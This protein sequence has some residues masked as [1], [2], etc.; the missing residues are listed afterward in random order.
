MCRYTQ[1]VSGAHVAHRLSSINEI[2]EEAVVPHEQ[3]DDESKK[4]TQRSA[5]MLAEQSSQS[6]QDCDSH[7]R[8][9]THRY[10]SQNHALSS[11]RL[12]ATEPQLKKEGLEQDVK[13]VW[14]STIVI[15]KRREGEMMKIREKAVWW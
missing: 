10:P 3:Q 14:G 8:D 4:I 2:K 7:Q 1:P 15:R 12:E 13:D 11:S 9:I 6:N 5:M